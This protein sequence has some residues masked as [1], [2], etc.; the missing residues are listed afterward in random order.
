MP[1]IHLHVSPIFLTTFRD[2]VE[3][4]TRHV[5]VQL[6]V[7]ADGPDPDDEDLMEAWREG[8]LETVRDDCAQLMLLLN[9]SGLGQDKVVL[10]EEAALS[11]LRACSAVRLKIQQLFLKPYGDEQLEEGELDFDEM[12]IELQQVYAC[13]IFL[14]G[15]QEVL[16]QEL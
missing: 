9:D 3:G 11:V 12:S 7:Q 15:L 5:G 6:A 10:S 4:F 1:E 2:L 8:L 14:A 13:Y 16:I